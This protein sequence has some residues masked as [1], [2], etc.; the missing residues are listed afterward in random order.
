VV[1]I[2]DPNRALAEQVA[3]DFGIPVVAR[4]HTEVIGRDDVDLV[5]VCTPSATHLA[6]FSGDP[7]VTNE[8]PPA[9]RTSWIAAVPTPLPP[10]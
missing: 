1:A 2:A 3:T 6:I 7:A 9:S 10:A 8:L 4:D 5:D